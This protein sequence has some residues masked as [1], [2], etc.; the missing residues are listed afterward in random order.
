LTWTLGCVALP[1]GGATVLGRARAVRFTGTLGVGTLAVTTAGEDRTITIPSK[2][3]MVATRRMIHY[4]SSEI[5][6]LR[7]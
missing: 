5:E 6:S 4:Q 7:R 3:S 2:A 1:D